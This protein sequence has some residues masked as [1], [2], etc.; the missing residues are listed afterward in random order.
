MAVKVLIYGYGN[1]GRQDDG[2]GVALAEK[3]EERA[4]RAGATHL[5]FDS[6]YQLN[7]EDALDLRAHDLVLF[8]DASMEDV[9]EF[10]VTHVEPSPE[11]EFTMHAVSPAFV[12]DVCRRLYGPPPPTYLLHIRG[13]A[14]ELREGCTPKALV[15][16][17]KAIEHVWQAVSDPDT[18]LFEMEA[19]LTKLKSISVT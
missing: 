19:S 6:N 16:L 13:Y 2:L 8:A 18:G 3:L 1:P 11:A 9:E 14:W 4:A 17:E 10:I 5:F 12:L 7:I 15:N